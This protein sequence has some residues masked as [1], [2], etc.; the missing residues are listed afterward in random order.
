MVAPGAND[1]RRLGLHSGSFDSLLLQHA[2]A[3]HV[4]CFVCQK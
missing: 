3:V 2:L 4:T 1:V